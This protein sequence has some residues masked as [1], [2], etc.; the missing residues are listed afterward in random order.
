MIRPPPSST[1][2][3][4]PFPYTTLFRSLERRAAIMVREHRHHP[5]QQRRHDRDRDKLAQDGE[6]ELAGEVEPAAPVED[7]L[8]QQAVEARRGGGRARQA[9]AAVAHDAI[10]V[11]PDIEDRKSVV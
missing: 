5:P 6:G 9:D 11:D 8:E 1:R 7:D 2:S 3:D 10:E 4:T